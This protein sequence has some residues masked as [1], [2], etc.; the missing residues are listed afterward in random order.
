MK[1]TAAF[2]LLALAASAVVAHQQP[3]PHHARGLSHAHANGLG[4]RALSPEEVKGMQLLRKRQ[5]SIPGLGDANSDTAAAAGASSSPAAAQT[6]AAAT[7]SAAAPTSAAASTPG[8]ATTADSASDTTQSSASSSPAAASDTAATDTAASASASSSSSS[9]APESSSTRTRTSASA[10]SA[11]SELSSAAS[12]S[13]SGSSASSQTGSSTASSASGSASADS[14]KKDS[15]GGGISKATLIPIIV[16]A[17]C[18]AGVAAIWTIIRK[19]KFSPSRKFE[20]KLEP[21]DFVPGRD[22]DGS[23]AA[24]G[25]GA[26]DRMFAVQAYDHQRS[27]SQASGGGY[28]GAAGGGYAASL[29]RSD[30]GKDSLRG[31]GMSES[32]HGMASI[33]YNGPSYA[34][35]PYY[36][37]PAYQTNMQPGYP[38]EQP[39]GYADLQRSG[40]MAS[41]MGA[42]YPASPP[43][44][45]MGTPGAGV[46]RTVTPAAY[47]Y[48]AQARAGAASRNGQRY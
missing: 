36:G 37:A 35:A 4:S 24:G 27:V 44:P 47:D 40:M 46:Q 31:M 13:T 18:V 30:S 39:Y 29:A 34:P 17:S 48:A 16:V 23:G 20:A 22:G 32:G 12:D 6:S 9:A 15:G 10:S 45:R 8:A 25:R 2:P 21:I 42:G 19:T 1:T 43:P 7:N 14:D 33:P 5:I 38:H 11:A 26:H 3:S 41:A 28:G